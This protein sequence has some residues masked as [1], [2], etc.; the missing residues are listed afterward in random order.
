MS[1]CLFAT[2]ISHI[3]LTNLTHAKDP[4]LLRALLPFGHRHHAFAGRM[5]PS[6]TIPLFN[7]TQLAQR[8]KD[9]EYDHLMYVFCRGY[10]RKCTNG[11]DHLILPFCIRTAE[12][13]IMTRTNCTWLN[14]RIA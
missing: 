9:G 4:D 8:S 3:N 2:V 6:D 14:Y 12:I 13:S 7:A 5:R 10:V 11:A 1:L